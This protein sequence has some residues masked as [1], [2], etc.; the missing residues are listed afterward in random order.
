MGR[1]HQVGVRR[2]DLILFDYGNL[3]DLTPRLITFNS[4]LF[5]KGRH[6]HVNFVAV[7]P[8]R[9]VLKGVLSSGRWNRVS[10]GSQES[11]GKLLLPPH[12]TAYPSRLWR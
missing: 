6:V 3:N 12:P 8:P 4:D 1:R 2:T 5:P 10:T 11:R 9:K 7:L